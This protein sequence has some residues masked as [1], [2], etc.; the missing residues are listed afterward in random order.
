MIEYEYRALRRQAAACVY[1][2]GG[3]HS[4][5]GGRAHKQ[6]KCSVVRVRASPR[7]PIV[8]TLKSPVLTVGRAAPT[9]EMDEKIVPKTGAA[10]IAPDATAPTSLGHIISLSI[11]LDCTTTKA[12]N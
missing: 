10:I 8:K 11:Y 2:P 6:C 12:D 7:G 1:A 4:A 5:R 9:A 3:P